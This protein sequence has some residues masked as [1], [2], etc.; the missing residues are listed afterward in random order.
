MDA[1]RS[2]DFAKCAAHILSRKVWSVPVTSEIYVMYTEVSMSV[3]NT[4]EWLKN[5]QLYW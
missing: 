3:E 5:T 1:L 4:V 2:A